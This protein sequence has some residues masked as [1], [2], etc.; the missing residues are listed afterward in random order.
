LGENLLLFPGHNPSSPWEKRLL[1]WDY[2]VTPASPGTKGRTQDAE[3]RLHPGQDLGFLSDT[4]GSSCW[5]V[6]FLM[7]KL[8]FT[9]HL[10]KPAGTAVH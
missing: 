3:A 10:N 9:A 7:N 8:T 5:A 2:L 6:F 4:A 1:L